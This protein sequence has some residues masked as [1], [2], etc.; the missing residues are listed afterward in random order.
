M[1]IS[2]KLVKIER[3]VSFDTD[4]QFERIYVNDL[5][6]PIMLRLA[7]GLHLILTKIDS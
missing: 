2:E 7:L 3:E 4:K 1:S 6:K 5:L